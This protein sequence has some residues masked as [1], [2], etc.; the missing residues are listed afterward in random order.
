[1]L[2]LATDA[3]SNP[4]LSPEVKG[5][6]ETIRKNVELEARLIDDLLDVTRITS[7]KMVL[8]RQAVDIHAVLRDSIATIRGELDSKKVDLITVLAEGRPIVNGDPVRLQ[9]VFWNVLKNAVKFTPHTGSVT[10][11]TSVSEELGT[12]VVRVSDTGIGMSAEDL[13][14]VFDAF[15]Q[16]EHAKGQG[17][18]RFGG[19]GLGLAISRKLVELHAG[20]ISA[21][22]EGR[23]K[24]STFM[25][26]LPLEVPAADGR[27]PAAVPAERNGDPVPCATD[28]PAGP[29]RSILLVEDHLPTRV[30][31]DRLLKR[32]NFKVFVAGTA[33]EAR[34]L[35]QADRIDILIS[36]IGLPDGNGY[37]LMA[38]LKKKYGLRGIALTG[39]GMEED[40]ARSRANGFDIHLIKP[41]SIQALDAALA[42]VSAGVPA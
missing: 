4:N 15:V 26:E 33:G 10:V 8:A 24:G 38:E 25:I 11:T 28:G 1:M 30:A 6:F 14:H 16:G 35:A 5:D 27:E 19:L 39:Y 20:R 36:D 12:I 17:S 29:Q 32:R 2:L 22:S 40:I 42:A 41:V 23:G 9:Q 21:E 31:L 37:D 3:R 18:H 34:A 7:G 13:P